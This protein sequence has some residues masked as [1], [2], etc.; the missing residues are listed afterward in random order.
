MTTN[1]CAP[2]FAVLDDENG[3]HVGAAFD[4]RKRLRDRVDDV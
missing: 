3:Q 1:V 2:E 4:L